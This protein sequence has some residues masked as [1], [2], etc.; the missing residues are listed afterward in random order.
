MKIQN[1]YRHGLL[2]GHK[3]SPKPL[4][5]QNKEITVFPSTEPCWSRA[6]GVSLPSRHAYDFRATNYG[7][8][9]GEEDAPS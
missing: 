1:D 2:C 5:L 6:K 7:R 3:S 9:Y 8:H 4:V